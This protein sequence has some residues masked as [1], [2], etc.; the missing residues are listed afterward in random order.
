M[1][2]NNLQSSF[3]SKEVVSTLNKLLV[4]ECNL[5]NISREGKQEVVNI[6]IKNMKNV[7]RAIDLTK[8]NTVNFNSIFEQYKKHSI[9]F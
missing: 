7:Y 2:K 1:D 3:F 8:I 9:T 5:H 6:L 4:N